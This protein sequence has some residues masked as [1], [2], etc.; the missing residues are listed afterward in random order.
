MAHAQRRF[1]QRKGVFVERRH[2]DEMG[3]L[4]R[5]GGGSFVKRQSRRITL[6]D[7]PWRGEIIRVVYDKRR[8]AIVTVLPD[9]AA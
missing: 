1:L 9:T 7:I 4:I 2:L 3:R 5:A 6:W 8:K